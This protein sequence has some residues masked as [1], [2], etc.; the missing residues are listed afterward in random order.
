MRR[1]PT[2]LDLLFLALRMNARSVAWFVGLAV[3]TVALTVV[4]VLRTVTVGEPVSHAGTIVEVP[5]SQSLH[6]HVELAGGER[7]LV[8]RG[9]HEKLAVG[10]SVSVTE[11][12]SALGVTAFA[13]SELAD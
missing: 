7:V 9:E 12:Q 8:A 5:S 13:L 3:M 2:R 10:E 6:V 1:A 11:T 4:G